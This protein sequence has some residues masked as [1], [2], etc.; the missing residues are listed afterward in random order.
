MTETSRQ[1][2]ET[3]VCPCGN[4]DERIQSPLVRLL[5]AG[6]GKWLFSCAEHLGNLI[7][8]IW[9]SFS[10]PVQEMAHQI[11][12]SP[13]MPPRLSEAGPHQVQGNKFL[14]PKE[15]NLEK[16]R[17]LTLP[18]VIQCKKH[19]ARLFG[20]ICCGVVPSF[21]C[22][23]FLR[24]QNWSCRKTE[25]GQDWYWGKQNNLLQTH[26]S[27]HVSSTEDCSLSNCRAVSLFWCNPDEQGLP[28]LSDWSKAMP[29]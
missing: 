22:V 16:R 21:L 25:L 9:S 19:T 14:V 12:E 27:S 20:L 7:W 2:N 15:L 24:H 6:Q 13:A 3:A 10:P 29:L 17:I 5:P 4:K 8:S 26:T 28:Q 11:A 1:K 23:N 18:S